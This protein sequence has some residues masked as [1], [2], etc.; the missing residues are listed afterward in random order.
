MSEPLILFPL[1]GFR[2]V[3][4]FTWDD[5]DERPPEFKHAIATARWRPLA[6]AQDIGLPLSFASFQ[7]Y[8][9]TPANWNAFVNCLAI[10]KGLA[11][12]TFSKCGT[13][14]PAE[15]CPLGACGLL[16]EDGRLL[17][18]QH[19]LAL[20]SWFDETMPG[21]LDC[22]HMDSEDDVVNFE[23]MIKEQLKPEKFAKYWHEYQARMVEEGID[24]S[25]AG[26][27]CPVVPEIADH[28]PEEEPRYAG[29]RAC[30]RCRSGLDSPL[31]KLNI[32]MGGSATGESGSDG[33]IHS[34]DER[35]RGAASAGKKDALF[36]VGPTHLNQRQAGSETEGDEE[37]ESND[38]S[39]DTVRVV[40]KKEVPSKS[41]STHSSAKKADSG[42]RSGRSK[43]ATSDGGPKG[44]DSKP[45]GEKSKKE[46]SRS[47]K[48]RS[49]RYRRC[50]STSKEASKADEAPSKSVMGSAKD[51]RPKKHSRDEKE[52]SSRTSEGSKKE[53]QQKK[54]GGGKRSG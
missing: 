47:T 13:G 54:V 24:L 50:S 52:K 48:E 33:T 2:Q 4:S 15:P 37:P 51:A 53:K 44:F 29:M 23:A 19:V 27:E 5:A 30:E 7:P 34:S 46:S 43:P 8:F 1:G 42:K 11:T 26:L 17:R 21:M 25:F 3:G 32:E 39:V 41:E 45:S 36:R 49:T 14:F 18:V 9:G 35:V 20:A 12:H 28:R 22:F 40:E 38:E 6:L 16:R 10:D 31:R